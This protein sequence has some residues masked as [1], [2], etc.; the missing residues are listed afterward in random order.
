MWKDSASSGDRPSPTPRFA[1]IAPVPK[2]TCS[3]PTGSDLPNDKP[4]VGDQGTSKE[5]SAASSNGKSV[6]PLTDPPPSVVGKATRAYV[7][8][9]A[10]DTVERRWYRMTPV[11]PC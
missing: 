1:P 7:G 6:S 9:I 5:W 4:V 10:R 8:D 11:I 2:P 3:S